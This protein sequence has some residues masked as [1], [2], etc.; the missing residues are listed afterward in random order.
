MKSWTIHKK[1]EGCGNQPETQAD[2]EH[3]QSRCLLPLLLQGVK[4]EQ[5]MKSIKGESLVI[6]QQ[7][8]LPIKTAKSD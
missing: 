6:Y 1:K 8:A 3:L 2:F 7:L 5:E 4:K